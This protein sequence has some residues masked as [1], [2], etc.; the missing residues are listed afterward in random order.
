MPKGMDPRTWRNS[1]ERCLND[2]LDRAMSMI[3]AL[4][5]MEAD[6]DL[7]DTADDEPSI[8]ATTVRTTTVTTRKAVTP[9]RTTTAN[10]SCGPTR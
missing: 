10:R 4:D 9:S 1:V 3:T 5:L 2:L 6:C 7:D 8:G